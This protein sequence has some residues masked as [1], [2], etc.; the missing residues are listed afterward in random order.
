MTAEQI[1]AMEHRC[2]GCMESIGAVGGIC[3]HCGYD[4]RTRRNDAG[5]WRSG[6]LKNRYFVGHVLG[7]GGFAVS[8]IGYD[9]EL[10][11][12]VA[13]KEYYPD[14]LAGR[15]RGSGRLYLLDPS[16]AH[17]FE[18]G[19]RRALA[20][21]ETLLR[22]QEAGIAHVLKAYEAIEENNSVYIV[23]EYISGQPLNRMVKQEGALKPKIAYRYICAI[24]EAVAQMQEKLALSHGD[25]SPD[26]IMLRE[27]PFG[28]TPVLID[29]GAA[30]RMQENIGAQESKIAKQ[31]YSAPELLNSDGKVNPSTDCFSLCATLYFLLAGEISKTT[32]DRYIEELPSLRTQRV[33]IG[34]N[35]ESVIFKGMA[36]RREERY[37]NVRALLNA[38][39]EAVEKDGALQSAW[40]LEENEKNTVK[41]IENIGT[42]RGESKSNKRWL[43]AAAAC[44]ALAAAFMT[45]SLLSGGAKHTWLSVEMRAE[46]AVFSWGYEGAKYYDVNLRCD[47]GSAPILYRKTKAE[48]LLLEEQNLSDG[49][50]FELEVTA[51]LENGGT[52]TVSREFDI[53]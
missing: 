34:P 17:R 5:F 24:A 2:F 30:Q 1:K 28:R 7:R 38:L 42:K 22:L 3:P 16:Q 53:S 13:I 37:P 40:G 33:N 4:N 12:R 52:E 35:L 11:R 41:K 19:K 32:I 49:L 29:F 43:I 31:Y 10:D 14:E 47:D 51:Y 25:I 39:S 27:T 26:N 20:E 6:V 36:L 21:A 45:V 15:E 46:G 9:M 48:S 50:R 44:V 8:Y 18:E 23:M